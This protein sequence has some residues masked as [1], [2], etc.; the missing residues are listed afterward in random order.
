MY[1]P[2]SELHHCFVLKRFLRELREK[3]VFKLHFLDDVRLLDIPEQAPK[4]R[5]K[6]NEGLFFGPPFRSFQS[7][8]KGIRIHLWNCISIPTNDAN[9][10][11]LSPLR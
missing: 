4:L 1:C 3:D 6:E 7:K 11:I 8:T 5:S 2:R 10:L 9:S